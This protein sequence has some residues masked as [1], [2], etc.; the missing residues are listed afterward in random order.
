MGGGMSKYSTSEVFTGD[1][2]IDGKP[3]Y[4][5]VITANDLTTNSNHQWEKLL[6]SGVDALITAKGIMA[7][8]NDQS[9][10]FY[11]PYARRASDGTIDYEGDFILYANAVYA[12][13]R[14]SNNYSITN[15]YYHFALE[16]TKN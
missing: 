12:T 11:V 7:R 9:N 4:R 1:Y 5:K 10:F 14:G 8:P 15:G 13:F 6:V 3:I 2:W 16:Y